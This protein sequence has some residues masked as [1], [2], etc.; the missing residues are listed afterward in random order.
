MKLMW[1]EVEG[2]YIV[3]CQ[4]WNIYLVCDTPPCETY[5]ID[6]RWNIGWK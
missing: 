3:Q 2:K 1:V 6:R 5:Y 4:M